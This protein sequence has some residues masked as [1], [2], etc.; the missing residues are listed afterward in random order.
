MPSFSDHEFFTGPEAFSNSFH[1]DLT[2]MMNDPNVPKVEVT[3]RTDVKFRLKIEIF[4]EEKK[5]NENATEQPSKEQQEVRFESTRM[6]S[7]AAIDR[8]KVDQEFDI[9]LVHAIAYH[10]RDHGGLKDHCLQQLKE[11]GLPV[12][13]T[14]DL[15][16]YTCGTQPGTHTV[17]VPNSSWH[18]TP[19][20]VV[21]PLAG[22]LLCNNPECDHK[23]K[24]GAMNV[25][26][27]LQELWAKL[28]AANDIKQ[29]LA[30][31]K[32]DLTDSENE[33]GPKLLR[34]SRCQNVW[35]CNKECQRLAWKKHKKDCQPVGQT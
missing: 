11:Q 5:Q 1:Q 33:N 27:Q 22:F 14:S 26:D 35:F 15:M 20:T 31:K 8:A 28:Q 30:C 18:V 24:Q 12:S 34:C 16:C 3:F 7:T 9:W 6:L 23:A 21:D 32:M 2:A 10:Y 25:A 17:H 13:S 19:H 29:C 4:Q